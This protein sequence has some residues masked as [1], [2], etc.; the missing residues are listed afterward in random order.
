MRREMIQVV[1]ADGKDEAIDILACIERFCHLPALVAIANRPV[2]VGPVAVYRR[3]KQPAGYARGRAWYRTRRL[4]LS[5]GIPVEQE[6]AEELALHEVTHLA[7]NPT[8]RPPYRHHDAAFRVALLHAAW[9]VWPAT[10]RVRNQGR[11]YAMDARIWEA[12]VTEQQG[13][14]LPS[15]GNRSG[16]ALHGGC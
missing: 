7:V 3:S 8:G 1:T 11:V 12:A 4:M 14:G 15:G 13:R 9:E 16:G 5:Y 2:R 10:R 6:C